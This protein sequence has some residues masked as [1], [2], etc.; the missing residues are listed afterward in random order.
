MLSLVQAYIVLCMWV[1]A[2]HRNQIEVIEKLEG[3]FPIL[4][5]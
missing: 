1:S 3:A 2:D 4:P 5:L